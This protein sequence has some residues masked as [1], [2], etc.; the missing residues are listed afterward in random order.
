MKRRLAALFALVV[1][2][3]ALA[4]AVVITEFPRGL[5]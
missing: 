3:A 2:A 1:G 5:A 4:I